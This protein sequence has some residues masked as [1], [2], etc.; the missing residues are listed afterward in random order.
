VCATEECRR[1]RLLAEAREYERHKREEL[2]G[3]VRQL[4]DRSAEAIGIADAATIPLAVIPYTE[5]PVGPLPEHRRDALRT[6]LRELIR[7]AAEEPP[8]EPDEPAAPDLP[9]DMLAVLGRAC[10]QCGGYCCRK[11]G[12]HAFLRVNTV[13]R[14]FA[15]HPD[16]GPDECVE[17]YLSY[18][19][20][21][22]NEG[23]CVYH[24]PDGCALPRELRSGVCNWYLCD[25]LHEFRRAVPAG[26]PP[27]GF[28]ASAS[29]SLIMAAG[30]ID[31]TG[32]RPAPV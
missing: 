17:V 14:Y 32:T 9:P 6:H 31:A 1:Q 30:F 2:W 10:G 27:R 8:D 28:F 11:G 25:G 3:R 24:R 4:R 7:R 16:H 15:D 20:A 18:T 23:S 29:G 21:D 26:E 19:N 12:E 5:G 13:R 22:S